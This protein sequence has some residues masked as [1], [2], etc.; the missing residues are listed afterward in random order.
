MYILVHILKYF[1][2][3]IPIA[4]IRDLSIQI[5]K[6]ICNNPGCTG[7]FCFSTGTMPP[8]ILWK[9]VSQSWNAPTFCLGS[10]CCPVVLWLQLW[11]TP[12][13]WSLRMRASQSARSSG[14]A[15]RR[16]DWHMLIA[17]SSSHTSCL[18]QHSPSHTCAS[19][20]NCGT[21]SYLVTS[22][23]AKPRPNACA[24]VRLS[25]WWAWWWQP[26][27]S[28][29][30][31]SVCSMC[32]VILT[33][34]LLIS[35][36]SCLFNCC[37]TCVQWAPRAAIPSSTPGFMTASVLNSGKCSHV[38]DASAFQPTTV[39]QPVWFCEFQVF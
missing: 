35:A 30:C 33:L 4:K 34:I 31:P 17:L 24:S 28:A 10:G 21:A 8:S 23:R 39:P 29:G 2:D 32:Y 26:L 25:A 6:I 18:C 27:A 37:V 11:L 38:I 15:R 5:S 7:C 16:R 14:S 13:M 1:R 19:L 20:S 22:P 9:S 3:S 12:T 36:T